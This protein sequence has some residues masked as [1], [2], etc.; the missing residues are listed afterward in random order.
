MVCSIGSPPSNEEVLNA[1]K[2]HETLPDPPSQ[3]LPLYE[4]P[5]YIPFIRTAQNNALKP[6]DPKIFVEVNVDTGKDTSDYHFGQENVEANVG[7]T[8]GWFSIHASG[9]H[10]STSETLNTH[11]E[12]EK[13]SITMT[14][15]DLQVIT[16]TPG[17]W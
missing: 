10:E 5:S 9:G 2:K 13:I 3:R 11:S 14:F 4:A 8:D 6:Y 16:I 15:E 12:D 7:F 1:Q 17:S